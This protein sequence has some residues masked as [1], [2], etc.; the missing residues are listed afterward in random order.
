MAGPWRLVN[1]RELYDLRTDPG[2]RKDIANGN[3]DTAGR[4]R[5]AGKAWWDSLGAASIEPVRTTIGGPQDPVLLTPLDWQSRSSLPLTRDDVIRGTPANGQW[6][7]HVVAE[8]SYD[9]LI[10]RWPLTINR[11]LRDGF[12][13]PEKAR[14][15]MG[16]TDE[17]RAVT[18]ETVGVN[19]RVA[20]K[21]GPVAL[22]TWLTGEGKTSGA[23]FV[24][25][26]RAIEV[27]SAKPVP[28]PRDPV[29]PPRPIVVE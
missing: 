24:E 26:R 29:R 6:L 1:G 25:I 16:T 11:T 23:Y 28:Q 14:L 27:R 2:Q 7:L 3:A 17:F 15:R 8:G 5:E 18:P 22:Q 10:R 9:I 20:L 21:P 12:F 13:A 4:L 19:F